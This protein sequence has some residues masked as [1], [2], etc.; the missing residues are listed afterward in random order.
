M[1]QKQEYHHDHN[2]DTERILVVKLMHRHSELKIS[3]VGSYIPPENSVYADEADE[4]FQK[5]LAPAYELYEDSIV[6]IMLV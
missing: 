3:I 6:I 2:A 1:N 4:Y 5:L